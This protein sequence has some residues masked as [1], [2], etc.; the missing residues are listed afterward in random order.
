MW[1]NNISCS[2]LW[3]IV[4]ISLPD[5]LVNPKE[6]EPLIPAVNHQ[7]TENFQNE[8][9]IVQARVTS[10]NTYGIFT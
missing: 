6:Y 1:V 8:S 7:G 4:A 2:N 5:R 3:Y 9:Y 10:M